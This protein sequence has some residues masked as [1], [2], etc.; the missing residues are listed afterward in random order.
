MK[1]APEYKCRRCEKII[2]DYIF[3][4]TQGAQDIAEE[5]MEWID[6]RPYFTINAVIDSKTVEDYKIYY[7]LAHVCDDGGVGR[8]DFIG[9]HL[10]E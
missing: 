8:M 2:Q 7:S 10:E 6:D 9:V 3:E 4:T 5:V 1:A